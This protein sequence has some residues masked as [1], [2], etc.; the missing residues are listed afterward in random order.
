MFEWAEF[1]PLRIVGV[2][3]FNDIPVN[4]AIIV[5][6]LHELSMENGKVHAGSHILKVE[7]IIVPNPQ[8]VRVTLDVFFQVALD[9]GEFLELRQVHLIFIFA[10]ENQILT[11]HLLSNM[12]AHL[13]SRLHTH[14]LGLLGFRCWTW[15]NVAV[16]DLDLVFDVSMQWKW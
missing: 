12:Q 6:A 14:L 3:L 15:V 13:T 5:V 7:R 10:T 2:F 8:L 16:Q 4:L 1:E 11:S 9:C